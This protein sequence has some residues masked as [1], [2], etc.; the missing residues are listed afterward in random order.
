[1]ESLTLKGKASI[2]YKSRKKSNKRHG[3]ADMIYVIAWIR[4]K[5]GKLQDYLKLFRETAVTVRKEKGCLQYI[6]AVDIDSGL[7][8]QI[9]E[10]N[11]A[12]ILE[13]W[14]SPEALR[15]HLASPHM[16]AH[17]EK[18]KDF[19]EAAAVKVLQEV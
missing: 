18:E 13:K 4:T 10:K 16:K 12:T 17:M 15:D 2:L 5:E 19:V 3:G 7:P 8:I 9:F 14:E 11:V 1:M 6:V